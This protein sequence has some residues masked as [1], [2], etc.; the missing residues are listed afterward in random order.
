MIRCIG[1]KMFWGSSRKRSAEREEHSSP[2]INK[3]GEVCGNQA[4]II[5]R[6]L[7]RPHRRWT[8]THLSQ[9]STE[10]PMRCTGTRLFSGQVPRTQHLLPFPPF[11]H[12]TV[13]SGRQEA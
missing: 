5:V 13:P 10:V 8:A 9:N 11:P 12:S 7:V 6:D 4:R 3:H 1:N 2:C